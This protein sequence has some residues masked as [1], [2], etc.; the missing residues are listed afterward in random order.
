MSL[1]IPKTQTI[2]DTNLTTLE[3]NVGQTSPLNDKAFLRVLAVLMGMNMTQLY[4]LGVERAL[5]T[6]A[7]TATGNDLDLIGINYGVVRKAAV[8]AVL[9]V[10]IGGTAGSTIS[11]TNSYVGET[12]AERY[13]VPSTLTIPVPLPHLIQ[14]DLTAE[15]TGIAGNLADG[16]T[17][18]IAREEPGIGNT[19]SVLETVTLGTEE[20]S[21]DDYRIRI[22][23]EIRTVGGGSNAA[24]YRRWAQETTSVQRA[25]PY[26]GKPVGTYQGPWDADA[27]D[28]TLV[29]S[30]GTSGHYYIVGENG[31]T[32]LDGNS[33]WTTGDIV[34]FYDGVWNDGFVDDSTPGERTVYVQSDE[35][36]N[37][38]GI[39]DT[40]LLT[41]T[42]T[43]ITTDPDTGEDRQCL[44]STDDTLYLQS[45]VRLSFYFL[46]NNMVVT[47]GTEAD[48]E[49]DIEA[50]MD[51]FCR[52]LAPY[53]D[54]I[55]AEFD[56]NDVISRVNAS[57]S[58]DDVLRKYNGYADSVSIQILRRAGDIT[59]YVLSPGEMAKSGGVDF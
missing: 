11:A 30:V 54:G 48:A 43:S 56:K 32:N 14:P 28:P 17:L 26:T 52:E 13:F 12:N 29:S 55:D 23:D 50:E 20:E 40:A 21:D 18:T 59:A 22:L 42:R 51:V 8:A 4:R 24:D 3:T 46:V 53:V 7:I 16:S 10:L 6:L 9:K 5:Q 1:V 31:T 47:T 35:A 39:A 36:Y 2:I 33:S 57:K 58:V 38:D 27:N 41:A 25:Y 45:I 34:H 19:C 49:D 15:N 37:A 44:G